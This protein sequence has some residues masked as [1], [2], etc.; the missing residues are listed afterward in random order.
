[1]ILVTSVQWISQRLRGYGFD[2]QNH[3]AVTSKSF[4]TNEIA[5]KFDS[6]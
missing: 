1:M 6:Y 3:L 5:N 2:D 4:S